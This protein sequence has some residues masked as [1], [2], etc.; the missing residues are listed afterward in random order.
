MKNGQCFG[1]GLSN[2]LVLLDKNGKNFSSV[3]AK[4]GFK[5]S[6]KIEV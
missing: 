1:I 2:S 3:R 4:R 5:I 6:Q